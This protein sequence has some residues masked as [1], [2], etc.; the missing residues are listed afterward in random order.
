MGGGEVETVNKK[1]AFSMIAGLS[2]HREK[3]N[4]DSPQK[5]KRC[6]KE[7]QDF[8]KIISITL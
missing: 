8:K 5:Y 2:T 3:Y 6:A 4:V 1:Q 7:F